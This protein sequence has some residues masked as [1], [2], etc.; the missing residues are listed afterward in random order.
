MH[1]MG[2]MVKPCTLNPK[3]GPLFSQLGAHK[4]VRTRIW[5]WHSGIVLMFSLFARQWVGGDQRNKCTPR[6]AR[7]ALI[8]RVHLPKKWAQGAPPKFKYLKP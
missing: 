3:G 8:P 6:S 4:T 5:S 2:P 1:A 7:V